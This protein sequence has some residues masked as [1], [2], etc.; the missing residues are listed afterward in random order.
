MPDRGVVRL[1]TPNLVPVQVLRHPSSLF[2]RSSAASAESVPS[3]ATSP[4]TSAPMAEEKPPRYEGAYVPK[5]SQEELDAVYE[6][7]A[8]Q[9]RFDH[10]PPGTPCSQ[11]PL[12][13]YDHPP[14]TTLLRLLIP[15]PHSHHAPTTLLPPLPNSL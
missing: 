9:P 7:A 15:L 13:S 10:P 11:S 6:Q 4:T 5:L 3:A 12:H 14:A 2:A 1:L 8:M